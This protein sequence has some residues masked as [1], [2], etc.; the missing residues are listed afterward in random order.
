MANIITNKRVNPDARIMLSNLSMAK[1]SELLV[2][3][4]SAR[5]EKDHEKDLV[6]WIAQTDQDIRGLG[7]VSF[8]ITEIPWER[9]MFEEQKR[10]LIRT[11]EATFDLEIR[12]KL[13]FDPIEPYFSEPF[14]K[15]G[16]MIEGFHSK[17]IYPATGGGIWDFNEGIKK[18]DKCPKHDV[19]LHAQ[20][21]IICGNP[22]SYE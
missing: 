20:G 15:F 9:I 8:D 6:I 11:V 12:K 21:C 5:A 10:F 14:E 4:G 19:L 16:A 13:G 17:N 7:M 22:S 2:I 18:H 3:A 1:F